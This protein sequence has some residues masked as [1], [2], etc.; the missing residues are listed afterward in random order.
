MIKA[1]G[2]LPKDKFELWL[3]G[4]GVRRSELEGLAQ[5]KGVSES[6]KFWGIRNDIPAI[7]K[8]SDIVVMSS[9]FEGLSLSSI[10]GMSV[11]KPFIASDVD[12]LREITEG[13]GLLF[14]HGNYEQLA[15]L[16]L[17]LSNNPELNKTLSGRCLHRALQYDIAKMVEGYISVYE[18]L[19]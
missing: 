10:E 13:A 8:S 4:D 19:L 5:L 3:V 17:D 2:L 1:F 9:H 6:T 18:S 15:K 11:G 12:G 16:I 14:E 7:L